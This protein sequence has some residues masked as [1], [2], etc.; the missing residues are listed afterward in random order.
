M[1]NYLPRCSYHLLYIWYAHLLSNVQCDMFTTPEYGNKMVSLNCR[2]PPCIKNGSLINQIWLK[3]RKECSRNWILLGDSLLKSFE[4]KLICDFEIKKWQ[5]IFFLT[6]IFLRFSGQRKDGRNLPKT[7]EGQK[8][9]CTVLST[10]FYNF[11]IQIYFM[12]FLL[13]FDINHS[14]FKLWTVRLTS[15]I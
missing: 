3:L 11:F 10:G 6:F 5:A 15:N 9:V 7:S 2:V 12:T 1:C 14:K 4:R 13:S 8:N